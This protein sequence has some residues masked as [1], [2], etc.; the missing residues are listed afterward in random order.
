M[1]KLVSD[2]STLVMYTRVFLGAGPRISA[3]FEGIF[4]S[5]MKETVR[6]PRTSRS[7]RFS[8]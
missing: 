8:C 7:P 3:Y 6:R 2:M 1:K 4:R 5:Q